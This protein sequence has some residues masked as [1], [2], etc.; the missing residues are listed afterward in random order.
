MS[1]LHTMKLDIVA[2][3]TYSGT[4][5]DAALVYHTVN[6][7][8]FIPGGLLDGIL[9]TS[10]GAPIT[11]PSTQSFV[12]ELDGLDDLLHI[13]LLNSEVAILVNHAHEYPVY[14]ARFQQTNLVVE[15]VTNDFNPLGIEVSSDGMVH[16]YLNSN[17]NDINYNKHYW[18]V[19][20]V[21]TLIGRQSVTYT[22]GTMLDNHSITPAMRVNYSLID[23]STHTSANA[24][25]VVFDAN[26]DVDHLW[27]I[28]A[29]DSGGLG[30]NIPL[31]WLVGSNTTTAT[32]FNQYHVTVN[33]N[34]NTEDVTGDPAEALAYRSYLNT[35][36]QGIANDSAVPARPTAIT[37]DIG[38]R[39]NSVPELLDI[40]V[41][42]IVISGLK[43]N[44]TSIS[45][46]DITTQ[47]NANLKVYM[48]PHL[49][50]SEAFYTE[51]PVSSAA[52]TVNPNISLGKF[53]A[54]ATPRPAY[55]DRTY[56]HYVG[57]DANIT[58]SSD[59][60]KELINNPV[61]ANELRLK[62]R[63]WIM[64]HNV[65]APYTNG[66]FDTNYTDYIYDMPA[67]TVPYDG[68]DND[69]LYTVFSRRNGLWRDSLPPPR[70]ASDGVVQVFRVFGVDMGNSTELNVYRQVAAP[71][72][73]QLDYQAV[74]NN[75]DSHEYDDVG[76]TRT[77][78]TLVQAK[79]DY[80]PAT[81]DTLRTYLQIT[82]PDSALPALPNN[83]VAINYTRV[84]HTDSAYVNSEDNVRMTVNRASD[85]AIVSD[86]MSISGTSDLTFGMSL[87][88]ENKDG[89]LANVST[90]T[91][92]G[93]ANKAAYMIH[94][95]A[96]DATLTA[97]IEADKDW[98]FNRDV[99]T[100]VIPTDT[101]MEVSCF[102]TTGGSAT[103]KD[104]QAARVTRVD[105]ITPSHFLV[106]LS[107][108]TNGSIQVNVSQNS[109]NR[110]S[111]TDVTLAG[112][113]T[114]NIRMVQ[115][116]YRGASK[117]DS[118]HSN[119][120]VSDTR[121]CEVDN[122]TLPSVFQL[123]IVET[124][125]TPIELNS[126][127]LVFNGTTLAVELPSFVVS[128]IE[129][130]TGVR[131]FTFASSQETLSVSA[132]LDWLTTVLVSDTFPTMVEGEIC[133]RYDRTTDTL[134]LRRYDT[135]ANAWTIDTL[136]FGASVLVNNSTF[137][138]ALDET[139]NLDVIDR[140][141][142]C[143]RLNSVNAD[144]FIGNPYVEEVQY[145][146]DEALIRANYAVASVGYVQ[147][148]IGFD[149]PWSYISPSVRVMHASFYS[150]TL[151]GNGISGLIGPTSDVGDI[152]VVSFSQSTIGGFVP[153]LQDVANVVNTGP[154]LIIAL[155][156][157]STTY[158]LYQIN[159]SGILSLV[160]TEN[161]QMYQKDTYNFATSTVPVAG[162]TCALPLPT[163]KTYRLPLFGSEPST[164]SVTVQTAT[165]IAQAY[166]SRSTLGTVV[167]IAAAF[168]N[169]DE[170]DKSF[171]NLQLPADAVLATVFDSNTHLDIIP[172]GLTV[173]DPS[174]GEFGVY[175][176]Y[177]THWDVVFKWNTGVQ[178][179]Q[180]T[181]TPVTSVVPTVVAT[182]TLGNHSLPDASVFVIDEVSSGTMNFDIR[183]NTSSM[184]SAT[185]Y[186]EMVDSGTLRLSIYSAMSNGE[187]TTRSHQFFFTTTAAIQAIN[188]V[189]EICIDSL[190]TDGSDVAL[191]DSIENSLALVRKSRVEYTLYGRQG[192][193]LSWVAL[194]T[195]TARVDVVTYPV[196]PQDVEWSV[197]STTG[198]LNCTETGTVPSDIVSLNT[199]GFM[200]TSVINGSTYDNAARTVTLE[201]QVLDNGV[202]QQQ[203]PS[204]LGIADIP[205][206]STDSFILHFTREPTGYFSPATPT[207]N[208]SL[209]AFTISLGSYTVNGGS[210]TLPTATLDGSG[211]V[212][213]LEDEELVIRLH[214]KAAVTP[215]LTIG[216]IDVDLL[217]ISTPLGFTESITNSNEV[218]SG[219][220]DYDIV[221][222]RDMG[223]TEAYS[224]WILMNDV[225][226][227][228]TASPYTARLEDKKAI[229]FHLHSQAASATET[230]TDIRCGASG[231]EIN[232]LPVPDSSGS[233]IS[234]LG[235]C[236]YK[237]RVEPQAI[238]DL[239]V[240]ANTETRL[241]STGDDYRYGEVSLTLSNVVGVDGTVRLSKRDTVTSELT[242]VGST[243]LSA[244]D[245][246]EV[247]Y[248]LL[249]GETLVITTDVDIVA[250]L[251]VIY[252]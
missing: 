27:G 55:N 78:A 195:V 10:V 209:S 143:V 197:C 53:V 32:G 160:Q 85:M 37:F 64:G 136:T 117:A 245:I 49:V 252:T 176:V 128:G 115:Q 84:E 88:A 25:D 190:S 244:N 215:T 219:S 91:T 168:E 28:I 39:T 70:L 223:A 72:E 31:A 124:P 246:T 97:D 248:R 16:L 207:D 131:Q 217:L 45:G 172:N 249:K 183:A 90:L 99:L 231:T 68:V 17:N 144:T 185:A 181:E 111:S 51:I 236:C 224:V 202:V 241:V 118:H 107:L 5:S 180:I 145:D 113:A 121:L 94:F 166:V 2:T 175:L 243:T 167:T 149:L 29:S 22:Q 77:T 69:T 106:T 205:T 34:L 203:T 26:G 21:S 40:A 189:S 142:Y 87:L 96:D 251:T 226:V 13:N 230:L 129:G 154:C 247:S 46:G 80:Y 44:L 95:T 4:Y 227:Y 79:P 63:M 171:I 42:D 204:V 191:L 35:P 201:T 196:I 108:N 139:I 83:C 47:F 240:P 198:I 214:R 104:V 100:V 193:P 23:S 112:Y 194:E 92:V 12:V 188:T 75:I 146:T 74:A 152:V 234:D 141:D 151:S 125:A 6:K 182:T 225:V 169:N 170:N 218:L 61:G 86:T 110:I 216:G 81:G 173:P 38:E 82:A 187:V 18:T 184:T 33:L 126:V 41:G 62:Y 15:P 71:L 127:R 157:V 242:D 24:D 211:N 162:T 228:R 43:L 159:N 103:R 222:I 105:D 65:I 164:E 59:A 156:P 150:D 20:S 56:K 179:R 123:P 9:E 58:A 8:L 116:L 229:A 73:G 210:L 50:D 177:T 138:G 76:G 109:S 178:V 57:L 7:K 200:S 155:H 48:R 220:V 147:D 221:F 132:H 66:N 208:D 212:P 238:N 134:Q 165:N 114:G 122:N 137:T 239:P 163:D 186:T 213:I 120:T 11:I 67:S 140:P 135:W 89:L 233:P 60:T 119:L 148:T 237:K 52:L 232:C 101:G 133:L 30:I 174:V 130:E 1:V 192:N 98:F 206:G 235:P 102:H 161:S 14:D 250:H 158:S 54:P 199:I 36:V 19:G 3:T 153:T 93:L